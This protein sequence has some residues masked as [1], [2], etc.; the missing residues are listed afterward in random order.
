MRKEMEIAM[1]TELPNDESNYIQLI[2]AKEVGG[3]EL[4]RQNPVD[5]YKEEA[6]KLERLCQDLS[7]E[8]QVVSSE[9]QSLIELS[10]K[11][12]S[13]ISR[14]TIEKQKRIRS[15]DEENNSFEELEL[16]DFA[17]SLW[18]KT[19][20]G[21]NSDRVSLPH[22]PQPKYD[23]KSFSRFLIFF[24]NLLRH[25]RKIGESS[26]HGYQSVRLPAKNFLYKVYVKE[27]W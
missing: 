3:V 5:G 4:Q 2:E 27:R 14:M 16:K 13:D 6:E 10:N 22:W 19:I 8:L 15:E 12:Q 24:H 17:Q 11:L 25:Y 7:L 18:S 26:H 21:S 23:V 1:K 9:N 20:G